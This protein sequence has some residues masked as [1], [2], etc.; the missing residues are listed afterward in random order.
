MLRRLSIH[1]ISG[2]PEFPQ[3]L[4]LTEDSCFCLRLPINQVPLIYRLAGKTL[5]L[6]K[7]K[8]RLGLP[9]SQFITPHHLY[10]RLAIIRG[11]DEPQA[12]ITTSISSR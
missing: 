4:H 5:T 2:K 8:I 3:L 11:F 12:F 10:S 1:P 7:H 9:E 6:N